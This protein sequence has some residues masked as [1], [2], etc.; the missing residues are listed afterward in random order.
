M[1]IFPAVHYTMGGLWV[2]YVRT[3]D[4]G[5]QRAAPRNMVTSIP[6]LYAIGEC[7]YQYHGANRLGA[8]SLVSCIFDGLFTA[9]GLEQLLQSS[10]TRAADLPSSLFERE[11]KRHE[12]S[13]QDLF[14][15]PAGG[16][17][18]YLLHLALGEV[19]TK[20]ATVV[21]RNAQL[22]EALGQVDE[23]AQRAK[24][25][26]LSDSS[27]WTNQ[28]VAFTRALGDMFPLAKAILQ[29]ALARDEC[30]GAHFKPDFEMP[31][32]TAHTPAER[33]TQAEQ[34]CDRFEQN[35]RR[36][37]KSTIATWQDRDEAVGLSYEDVDT[38]LTP[39]R[40]RLYGLAG[41]DV[42]DQVWKER[43]AARMSA[44]PSAT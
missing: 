13:Y 34:W 15:R 16:E 29:G 41:A 5:L 31:H 26:A 27:R 11:T 35:N 36:W 4:G 6:G 2:D 10:K 17:N 3:A 1:K 21:R 18:P 32:L 40:P 42:I 8:N 38:S 37:L 23:L 24:R 12:Q 14:R 39:P 7:N 20:A 19:L 43:A 44:P 33:R 30:R 22:Q 9:P 28:N 25:C